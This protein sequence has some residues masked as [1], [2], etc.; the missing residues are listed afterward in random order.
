M[1]NTFSAAL[2]V[3]RVGY[4]LFLDR[5][6]HHHR[7]QGDGVPPCCVATNSADVASL[8]AIATGSAARGRP[9]R[10]GR[11]CRH[12]AEGGANGAAYC[13]SGRNV[14]TAISGGQVMWLYSPDCVLGSI[15]EGNKR[16]D[17][18]R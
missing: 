18:D 8:E 9:E 10:S 3:M 15:E 1:T 6:G 2:K 11:D 17:H 5:P 14:V 16:A 7:D 12:T 13:S 4:H